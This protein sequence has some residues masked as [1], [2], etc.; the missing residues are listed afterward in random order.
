MTKLS[1][2]TTI[3]RTSPSFWD[4]KS[5][6]Y[7]NRLQRAIFNSQD[8]VEISVDQIVACLALVICPPIADAEEETDNGLG[9]FDWS[10]MKYCSD[11]S[12]NLRWSLLLI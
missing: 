12:K 7:S 9:S 10:D 4:E 1:M 8:A 3:F 5:S 6:W 11:I 2:P